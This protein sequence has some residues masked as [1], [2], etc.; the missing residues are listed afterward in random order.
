METVGLPLAAHQRPRLAIRSGGVLRLADLKGWTDHVHEVHEGGPHPLMKKGEASLMQHSGSYSILL[1]C[2]AQILRRENRAWAIPVQHLAEELGISRES[3]RRHTPTVLEAAL[4]AI[5]ARRPGR[6]RLEEK[7]VASIQALSLV[8]EMLLYVLV[9]LVGPN[10][11][12]LLTPAM[13][14][15]LG[16]WVRQLKEHFAVS[17]LQISMWLGVDRRTIARWRR[18]EKIEWIEPASAEAPQID[19]KEAERIAA[20]WYVFFRTL[21]AHRRRSTNETL[22]TFNRAFAEALQRLGI[23]KLPYRRARKAEKRAGK[24]TPAE[25]LHPRGSYEYP[26]PFTQLVADTTYL[27]LGARR[28]YL[29]VLMDIGSRVVLFQE[30]FLREDTDAVMEVFRE[31]AERFGLGEFVLIDRGTPYLNGA[32]YEWLRARGVERI[33]SRKATPTEKACLERYMRTF[34][35]WVLA[36]AEDVEL[37]RLSREDLLRALRLASRL[38]WRHYNTN[39]QPYIDEKDPLA[40]LAESP[41]VQR[42]RERVKLYERSD[43]S[44]PRKEEIADACDLLQLPVAPEALA[45]RLRGCEEASIREARERC[46]LRFEE[47][48]RD[49][50]KSRLAYFLVVVREIDK[51]RK[52]ARV[53]DAACQERQM[54]EKAR[55]E[56]D[57]AARL[58][59]ARHQE[60]CPEEILPNWIRLHLGGLARGTDIWTN[61]TRRM[62]GRLLR[63]A[64]QKLG[65]RLFRLTLSS[66]VAHVR[67]IETIRSEPDGKVLSISQEVRIDTQQMLQRFGLEALEGG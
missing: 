2:C 18:E 30:V 23:E 38:T 26:S 6:P 40:R 37:A 46:W 25:R 44:K 24:G 7:S 32:L 67:T 33:V 55:R 14:A 65:P 39:P 45:G 58:A 15:Q 47:S 1:T 4:E 59:E 63:R 22:R 27:D 11:P 42:A 52:L 61:F 3:V 64:C 31:A 57:E 41:V 53:E 49:P 20:S 54:V 12:S 10:W 66:L 51:K 21:P 13:R 19:R 50:V 28:F 60:E 9:Q 8:N 5:E 17:F 35:E 62:L 16:D 36:D 48:D 43:T 56:A 29:V 34:K